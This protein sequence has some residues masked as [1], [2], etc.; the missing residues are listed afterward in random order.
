MKWIT[1]IFLMI[2]SA[3]FSC[4]GYAQ[5][6]GDEFQKAVAAYQQAPDPS[7]AE[8]IIKL[9][10]TMTP[11]PAVPEEARRHYVIAMTLLKD[12]KKVE[13]FGEA[14]GELKSALLIAPWWPEANL[15]LGMAL[16]SAEKYDEAQGALKFYL[17]TGPAGEA[18]RA[19]Q[20][21]IYIIEA[22]QKKAVKESSPEVVAEK[23]ENEYDVWLKNLDGARFISSPTEW[24]AIGHE[25]DPAYT[26]YYIN[27]NEVHTGWIYGQPADF[28][29]V[30]ITQFPF[31]DHT[32]SKQIQNKQFKYPSYDGG[33][34]H[35]DRP[36][37]STISDDGQFLSTKCPGESVPF[38]YSRVK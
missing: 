11:A 34:L 28:N 31:N 5:S 35:V 9:A 22:K 1:F 36:C 6:T 38:I 3:A 21:E 14:V 8:K 15:R 19:A 17:L 10:Q 32:M 25:H 24:G 33:G 7:G 18:A 27:G 13:D 2:M 37:V 4:P 12:A 30:S 23:K 20:D 16:E 29:T 26:V